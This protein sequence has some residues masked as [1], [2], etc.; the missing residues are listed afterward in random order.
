VNLVNAL[1]VAI[2][3]DAD[4]DGAALRVDK[5]TNPFELLVPPRLLELYVL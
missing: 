3:V 5:T 2:V 4:V 1:Y